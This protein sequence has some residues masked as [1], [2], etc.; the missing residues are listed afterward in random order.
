MNVEPLIRR[1]GECYAGWHIIYDENGVPAGAIYVRMW[2]Q[3]NAHD[4]SALEKSEG[5]YLGGGIHVRLVEGKDLNDEDLVRKEKMK[6]RLLL[7][8][9]AINKKASEKNK[10]LF[11]E[12]FRKAMIEVESSDAAAYGPVGKYFEVA[13]LLV[14]QFFEDAEKAAGN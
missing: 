8:A 11:W 3:S 12:N 10:E 5:K 9:A 13:K 6:A 7:K 14:L 2:F 4:K 1:I